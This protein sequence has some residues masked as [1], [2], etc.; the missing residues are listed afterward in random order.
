M[1]SQEYWPTL[2]SA[3]QAVEIGYAHGCGIREHGAKAD[4][5]DFNIEVWRGSYRQSHFYEAWLAGFTAGFLN[6]P[7]PQPIPRAF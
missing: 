6:T 2:E 4:D 1:L 7:K 3:M 5:L